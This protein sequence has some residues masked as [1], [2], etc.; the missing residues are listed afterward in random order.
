MTKLVMKAALT[1]AAVAVAGTAAM[2]EVPKKTSWTAYGTTSSGYAQAVAIGNMLKKHYGTNMR[3]IPGK[4]DISR[5]AP[6]RDNKADYCACGIASYFGQEGVFIFADKAW[7][8]QPIR[9]LMANIGSFGLSLATAKDA[10]IKTIADLKGKRV[11]WVKGSPA[12]NWNVQA[13]MAFAGLTWDD[14]EKVTVSGFKASFEALLNGQADA[15][16]S[17]TV[18]PMPKRLAASPRGLHWP[19]LPHADSEGWARTLAVAPVYNKVKVTIGSEIDKSNPSELANYAYPLLVSN[20]SKEADEVYSIV[21]AMVEHYEDYNK[22]AKGALG[23]KL[24]NQNMMPAMPYHDGSIRY[25][26]ERGLWNADAQAH[27]DNLI[28]RQAVIK[29]AWDGLSGKDGMAKDVL[30]SEWNAARVGALK[31]AGFDPVFK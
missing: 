26:K 31:G 24:E 23:W 27:H 1:I 30:K 11:A 22:A 14:V 19:L 17:S 13:H 12:L 8:P 7:G 10:G 4:N 21:K 25:W 15:A 20:A 16:F 2:A 9:L 5:M 6:L 3:V 28:K 29:K 18:S